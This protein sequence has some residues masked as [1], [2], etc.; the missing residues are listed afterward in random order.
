MI[1]LLGIHK[2]NQPLN[3]LFV[4]MTN[5]EHIP[6]PSEEAMQNRL[7][8]PF[9]PSKEDLEKYPFLDKLGGILGYQRS[10]VLIRICQIY[11]M[12]HF[13]SIELRSL[14]K[15]VQDRTAELEANDENW[16]DSKLNSE[17]AQISIDHDLGKKY[18]DTIKWCQTTLDKLNDGLEITYEDKKTGRIG[19]DIVT[20]N[21]LRIGG[22][23]FTA[24]QFLEQS[25]L[26]PEPATEK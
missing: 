14:Y 10:P 9:E 21:D 3:F 2:L 22:R 4:K 24:F 16:S 12:L 23:F 5:F 19:T 17:R 20:H 18:V 7:L 13:L 25:E 11:T 8:I 26:T 1:P 6:F 15:K